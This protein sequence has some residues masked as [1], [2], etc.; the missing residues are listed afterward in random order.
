MKVVD[1]LRPYFEKSF[2]V[3]EETFVNDVCFNSIYRSR[4]LCYNDNNFS[5]IYAIMAFL[6]E[7][8]SGLYGG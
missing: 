3:N 5:D 8:K 1:E 7:R 4:I 6:K 2:Y